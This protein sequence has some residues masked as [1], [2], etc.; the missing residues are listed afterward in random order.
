MEGVSAREH[1][2]KPP[3]GTSSRR[4]G[5]DCAERASS[6]DFSAPGGR[7]VS[8]MTKADARKVG[9]FLVL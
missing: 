7:S 1:V 9:V 8:T 2:T 4:S 3:S 6:A 5:F